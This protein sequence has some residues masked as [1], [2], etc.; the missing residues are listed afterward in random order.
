MKKP[1]WFVAMLL[2]IGVKWR[3]VK[4]FFD[5]T[6]ELYTHEK[7]ET[8]PCGHG[9]SKEYRDRHGDVV[10][11]DYTVIVSDHALPPAG[12]TTV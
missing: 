4:S 6:A 3:N 11:R 1:D 9:V 7:L 2:W 5:F 12:S 8:L 10:R